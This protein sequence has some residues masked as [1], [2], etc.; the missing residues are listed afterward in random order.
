MFS[1]YVVQVLALLIVIPA[2]IGLIQFKKTLP[3]YYPFIFFIW[4]GLLN[5]VIS[6][7]LHISSGTNAVNSNIYVLFEGWLLLWLFYG[8]SFQTEK[9]KNIFFIIGI[10]LTC[11]WFFDN[12]VFNPLSRF[13]SA[14]AILYS[15]ITV[16]L[17]INQINRIL[18]EARE[19]I[20]RNARFI[21]C[22]GFVIYFAY[23]S[24]FEVF[25]IYD[26]GFSDSFYWSLFNILI[27]VNLLCNLIYAIALLWIP[28]KQRFTLP[29]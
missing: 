22:I 3:A 23:K 16:F 4:L 10:L 9:D 1:Y 19:S 25:Y 11:S 24:V 28:R 14:H 17:S 27:V 6:F 7:I 20:F 2:I 13:N 21:I 12:I 8:W 26:F 5:E 15:F 29:Y 18:V